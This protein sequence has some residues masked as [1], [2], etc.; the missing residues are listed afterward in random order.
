V[1]VVRRQATLADRVVSGLVA[2]GS[3]ALGW[4]LTYQ[5]GSWQVALGVFFVVL[6]LSAA[7]ATVIV[8]R[9]RR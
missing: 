1:E 3:V 4:W 5:P 8:R 2:A 6:P 7:T 9:R